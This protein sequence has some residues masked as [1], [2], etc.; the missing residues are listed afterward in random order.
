MA[1]ATN[2]E[3]VKAA[4]ELGAH[5]VEHGYI[6]DEESVQGLL[7]SNVWYVPTLAIT[8]LTP[9]QATTEEEQQ[10]VERKRMAPDLI[11][12]ADAASS[13]HQSWFQ[14]ALNAGV[15]MALGSDIVPLRESAL[16]ELGLWVKDGATPWQ[17]LLAATR[18]AAELCGVGKDLGTVEAGKLA[19]LI[20]VKENPLDNIDNLRRLLLVI[21]EGRVVSDKR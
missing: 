21:K 3:A 1:H 7:E 8:H 13:T 11:Q 20:V 19:D 9:E 15:K 18:N 17:A 2:P 10:W 16:L 14:N 6:M 12:R 5:T 4:V